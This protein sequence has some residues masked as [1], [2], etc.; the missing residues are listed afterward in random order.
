MCDRSGTCIKT[1]GK[2]WCPGRVDRLCRRVGG[3][4]YRGGLTA[5]SATGG[6]FTDPERAVRFDAG[7]GLRGEAP[8]DR[9][10]KKI[11]GHTGGGAARLKGRQPECLAARPPGYPPSGR[12][13]CPGGLL[14]ISPV[15]TRHGC[16][17]QEGASTLRSSGPDLPSHPCVVDRFPE[18]QV[19]P[20]FAWF[21]GS[22]TTPFGGETLANFQ[23]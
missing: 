5:V 23:I 18:G 10:P 11:L 19:V 12:L 16:E 20:C 14:P 4:T 21:C 3:S 2:P 9:A 13:S 6:R 15:S 1:T 22:F 17:V 8:G 7:A